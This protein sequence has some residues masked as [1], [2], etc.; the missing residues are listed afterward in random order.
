MGRRCGEHTLCVI[1]QHL[2]ATLEPILHRGRENLSFFPNKVW[3]S[4]FTQ[5]VT[6]GRDYGNRPG[7]GSVQGHTA[8]SHRTATCWEA[9]LNPQT[10]SSSLE[11]N[12]S[13]N[14]VPSALRLAQEETSLRSTYH[15]AEQCE[16]QS[17]ELL[18]NKAGWESNHAWFCSL[19]V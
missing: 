5:R 12:T 10:L 1:S 9:S 18:L 4:K 14:L 2:Q 16:R 8:S 7:T 13:D 17:S 15:T 11:T 19:H 3:P 6:D